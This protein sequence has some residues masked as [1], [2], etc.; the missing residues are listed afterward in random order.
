MTLRNIILITGL[1]L[2]LLGYI[3]YWAYKVQYL[4][5]REQLGAEITK[6]SGEIEGYK[7]GIATMTHFNGQYQWHYN[8]SLPR[9][10]NDAR[11]QY[12]I[13]FLELL[14]YSGMENNRVETSAPTRVVP[15]WNYRVS[16]QCEGSLSQLSHFLFEFYYAPFLH[17]L[18][19]LT[20][21]PMAGNTERLTFSMTINA[22][23]LNSPFPATSL[24][25]G[26]LPRLAYNDFNVYQTIANRN[27]LQVAR[28]GIDQADYTVLTG[29]PQIGNQT[30][31]WFTEQ[32]DDTLAKKKLGD[33]IYAGSFVGRIVEVFDDD[34]VIDRNGSRWLLSVGESLKEAFALPPESGEPLPIPESPEID[35][36]IEPDDIPETDE[37]ESIE[38]NE[39]QEETTE[40]S[41][42]TEE[43]G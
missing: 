15:G 6:L 20:L 13:W 24:P 36:P 38:T 32:L 22:L 17:R 10:Q 31:I 14:Q 40:S 9:I 33:M 25:K 12:L 43:N 42:T 41:D 29:L 19:S 30:E 39:P 35:E 1:T 21:T 16:V 34:I 7:Q 3:G 27:L 37:D 23:S 4:A 26:Y 28:G 5:P 18:T 2:F 11:T 8:R